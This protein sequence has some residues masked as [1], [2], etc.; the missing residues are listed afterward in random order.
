MTDALRGNLFVLPVGEKGVWLRY[1]HLFCDFLQTKMSQSYPD[2]TFAI[3]MAPRESI[4]H[5]G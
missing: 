1:H 4:C 2:E 3:R 5:T